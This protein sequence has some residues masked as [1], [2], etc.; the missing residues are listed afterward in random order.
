MACHIQLAMLVNV[1]DQIFMPLDIWLFMAYNSHI[2]AQTI[3]ITIT[4]DVEKA[5]QILS[6]ST[7][8]TLNTTELIKMAVGGFAKI[9]ATDMSH[10]DILPDEWDLLSARMF[11]EWA[12]EDGS[13]EVN[14]IS[15]NAKLKPFIPEPYVP[16]R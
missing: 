14:N 8:G 2:M 9:K 15:P 3:R 7:L 6:Q 11:Y 5:L 16:N 4:P 13:L 10:D 1:A 12:K